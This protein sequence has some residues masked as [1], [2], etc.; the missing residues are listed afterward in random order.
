MNYK[1]SREND[2][3]DELNDRLKAIEGTLDGVYKLLKDADT[4]K[5]N[6]LISMVLYDYEQ[7]MRSEEKADRIIKSF[8]KGR[9][10][11]CQVCGKFKFIEELKDGHAVC[12]VCNHKYL[13]KGISFEEAKA[14]EKNK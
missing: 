5:L 7:K 2:K 9:F 8:F 11:T 6:K 10:Q 4:A 12:E 1:S 3:Y 14:L 13:E